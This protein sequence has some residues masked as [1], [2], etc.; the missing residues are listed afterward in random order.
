[1]TDS[2]EILRFC[3]ARIYYDVGGFVLISVCCARIEAPQD[4]EEDTWGY[5]PGR[6]RKKRIQNSFWNQFHLD[7][8][9][10]TFS[11]GVNKN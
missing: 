7:A 10:T 3:A 6:K 9:H 11:P 8:F 5:C 1:M 2:F 4:M